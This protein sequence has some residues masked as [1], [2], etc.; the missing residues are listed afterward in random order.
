MSD[1]IKVSQ[2]KIADLMS[3]VTVMAERVGD[4]TST[5]AHAFLDGQFYLATGHSGCIDPRMFDAKIGADM[6]LKD[7]RAK[8][9]KKLW[10]LEGYLLYS[11][12]VAT[13]NIAEQLT[14]K[15]QA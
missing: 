8:A 5:V 13:E 11:L 2:E 1:F 6:A 4:S 10:E 12:T 15:E 3:R 14:Q 9:E 7:A